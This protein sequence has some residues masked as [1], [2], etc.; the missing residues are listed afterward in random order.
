[1]H[2]ILEKKQVSYLASTP[3]LKLIEIIAENI[4]EF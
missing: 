1:M 4:D 2:L 3:N